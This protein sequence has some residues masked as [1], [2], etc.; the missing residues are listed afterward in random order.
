[1]PTCDFARFLSKFLAV[2]LP[3]VR[4]VS[5]NTILSYRDSFKLLLVFFEECLNKKP[6]KLSV[7]MLTETTILD[8]LEWLESQRNCCPR[9]RNQRLAAIC[10]FM[11]YVQREYPENLREVQKILSI[12]QKK[13]ARKVIRFLSP[14]EVGAILSAPDLSEKSGRRDAAL[15]SLMY[16]SGARVQEMSDM[17]AIDVH[18]SSPAVVTLHGKG[19]KERQ[20]PI[21]EKTARLLEGY[22]N[23]SSQKIESYLFLNHQKNQLSRKGIDWILKK[24]VRKSR[25]AG[26]AL[27]DMPI[28]CHVFRHSKA[29][30]MLQAGIPLVYIRDFLGHTSVTA[31]EVYARLNNEIKRKAIEAAHPGIQTPEYPSWLEDADLMSW[32]EALA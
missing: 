6:E 30:H 20:V 28:T 1:M 8:F 9:T 27:P 32:L 23:E 11:R 15:L 17:K 16:D 31:T 18:T 24:Y 21:M 19:N 7:A 12:P 5:C 22:M 3:G 14:D 29:A 25:E 10:S 4:N 26:A 2:Y 13:S